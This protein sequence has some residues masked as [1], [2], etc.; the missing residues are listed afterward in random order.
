MV[1]A[2]P[3][4]EDEAERV[5]RQVK[6]YRQYHGLSQA[7]HFTPMIKVEA[8]QAGIR[9]PQAPFIGMNTPIEH[10]TAVYLKGLPA[11]TTYKD[12]LENVRAGKI[13]HTY[14]DA[15]N[16]PLQPS[17]AAKVAFCT[18]ASALK[19]VEQIKLGQYSVCGQRMYAG[20]W[21]RR[22]E[23]ERRNMADTRCIQI[24]GPAIMM[25]WSW[26]ERE[27]ATKM[28]LKITEF[29][30]VH[31][32]DVDSKIFQ[33]NFAGIFA[34]SRAVV[35]ALE[36]DYSDIYSYRYIPDPCDN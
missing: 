14:I 3:K 35:K 23:P 11:A 32:K 29:F 5:A 30:E 24:Q 12:L 25:E 13:W 10:S 34:Q 2:L 16:P 26:F 15:P 6:E 21:D 1:V 36:K 9:R 17:A 20:L 22:C 28:D 33:I 19:F 27:F 4:E 8:E 7:S 31:S 18:R